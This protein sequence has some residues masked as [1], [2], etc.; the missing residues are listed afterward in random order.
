LNG[1]FAARRG[2][3][4]VAIAGSGSIAEEHIAAH[5]ATGRSEIRSIVASNAERGEQLAARVRGARV[6]SSIDE[7]LADDTIDAIDICGHTDRHA[8]IATAAITSGKHVLIEKPPALD[9]AAFA[10]V[11]AAATEQ[12]DVVAM[13]GQTVRFQPAIAEIIRSV[14]RGDIGNVSLVHLTWYAGYVWPR[15]WRGWQLD[16]AKSGGHLVHNGMHAIDLAHHLIGH[17]ADEVFTR[18]WK[19]YAP[20][21][22]TPDSFHVLMRCTNGALAVLETSYGLRPP[23]SPL[24]RIVVAGTS[25]TLSHSTDDEVELHSPTTTATPAS[26]ADAMTHEI[27]AWLRAITSGGPSPIPL[28]HSYEA[29]ATAIAAQR[30]YESGQVAPIVIEAH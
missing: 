2:A 21:L 24:R 30:S 13:V 28:Q 12:P 22:P 29:L 6:V 11:L 23:C 8:N 19:T 9:L 17:R 10:P 15:A 20:D 16:P 5:L 3:T 7:V 26:I 27:D 25:G 18:G 1:P 14:D 4:R